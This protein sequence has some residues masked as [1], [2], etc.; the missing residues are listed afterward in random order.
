MLARDLLLYHTDPRLGK[1]PCKVESWCP[2]FVMARR[3]CG[4]RLMFVSMLAFL[5][6]NTVDC[7]SNR[8]HSLCNPGA[9][10]WANTNAT[11][12]RVVPVVDGPVCSLGQLLEM[13]PMLLQLKHVIPSCVVQLRTS[14]F[15]LWKLP[16]WE[17]ARVH[18]FVF[19]FLRWPELCSLQVYHR[20]M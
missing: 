18:G 14:W 2:P 4:L 17:L 5:K 13:W 11:C 8:I 1:L 12:M 19:A 9:C 16:R 3:T 10:A 6:T 15:S 7:E 20:Q